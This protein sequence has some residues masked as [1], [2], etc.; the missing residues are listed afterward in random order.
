LQNATHL[1]LAATAS[2]RITGVSM[3]R[4]RATNPIR[5]KALLIFVLLI[6]AGR[7]FAVTINDIGV[8]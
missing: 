4:I 6:D 1:A 2:V 5:A 3:D 7:I 8:I